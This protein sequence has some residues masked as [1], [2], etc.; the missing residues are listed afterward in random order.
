[1]ST[2]KSYRIATQAQKEVMLVRSFG[3]TNMCMDLV[4]NVA[5]LLNSKN[6]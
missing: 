3:A 2:R 1:M 4:A 5:T 6:P